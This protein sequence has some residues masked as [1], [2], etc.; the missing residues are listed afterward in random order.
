MQSS[1]TSHHSLDSLVLG[2]VT[3]ASIRFK[4]IFDTDSMEYPGFMKKSLSRAT[5]Q[6]LLVKHRRVARLGLRGAIFSNI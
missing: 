4:V 6:R 2:Y 3:D 5:F 1:E